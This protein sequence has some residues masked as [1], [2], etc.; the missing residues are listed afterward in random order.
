MNDLVIS[1]VDWN[2][3]RQIIDCLESIPSSVKKFS[4]KTVVVDNNSPNKSTQIISKLFPGTIIIENDKNI[5]YASAHN[6]VISSMD[7]RYFLLLNPDT[8]LT[9]QA[10]DKVLDFMESNP[11]VGVA[12]CRVLSA[13]GSV[14]NTIVRYPSLGSEVLR[15]AMEFFYPFNSVFKQVYYKFH[16]IIPDFNAPVFVD[17]IS[18]CFIMLRSEMIREI[19]LLEGSFFLFSEE[20]DLCLRARKSNW[21]CAYLP[22]ATVHHNLGG[23][24]EKA[25]HEFSL[26][27][28]YRSRL[29]YFLKHHG[30][31][32]A[33]ILGTTYLIFSLWFLLIQLLKKAVCHCLKTSRKD[34]SE[35]SLATLKAV[36]HL[37]TERRTFKTGLHNS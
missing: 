9:E 35:T 13:D 21:C 5:G 29:L 16:K 4:Y 6:Q 20:I 26:Y 24:R 28:F 19:G 7:S 11:Q 14:Q 10:I 8:V 22:Q 34:Y 31:A 15:S 32:Q 1:I 3:G 12:G 2:S 17:A 27:H 37:L 23:C 25:S 30:K 18:G 36:M 33:C